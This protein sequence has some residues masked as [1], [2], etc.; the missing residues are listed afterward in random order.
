M[1]AIAPR[2]ARAEAGFGI[3][4]IGVAAV[5]GAARFPIMQRARSRI[6]IAVFVAAAAPSVRLPFH[7]P[8]P[9]FP[10]WAGLAGGGGRRPQPVPLTAAPP[11]RSGP[12]AD[13][14][15]K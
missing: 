1:V 10:G 9:R 14:G 15:G 12:F 8:S 13:R 3:A 6:A 5:V 2:L 4:A 7:F 11:P